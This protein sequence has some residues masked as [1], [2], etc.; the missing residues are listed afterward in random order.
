MPEG[1]ACLAL[2]YFGM[3]GLPPSLVD[4]PLERIERGLRWLVAHP[5]VATREGR[6]GVV[7]VSRGGEL[8]LLVAATFPDLVGPVTA[9]TP[10]HVV[11]AGIDYTA[12]PRTVLSSWTHA[13]SP[14]PVM[15]YVDGAMPSFSERGMVLVTIS[16]RAL[17]D[18]TAVDRASIPIERAAGPL[19]LISG[20]D[21]KVWPA[22]RMCRMAVER[23]LAHGRAG[24]I[25]HLHYPDAGHGLFPY[26]GPSAARSQ[27][28]IRLD[29]GGSLAAAEAAHA[30]AWPRVA[31]HLRGS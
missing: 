6:V 11:W 3:E 10:S 1:V 19:L 5:K 9:Y 16:D 13:G 14:L 12:A 2:G 18:A 26:R 28:P 23:M 20:G 7:G 31:A 22:E 4:V 29:L 27:P 25:S 8:A 30:D 17:D 15:Q 24:D 21:D